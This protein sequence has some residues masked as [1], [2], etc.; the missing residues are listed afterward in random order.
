MDD[1]IDLALDGEQ[2][3]EHTGPYSATDNGR[4]AYGHEVN[5]S[6]RCQYLNSTGCPRE[7]EKLWDPEAEPDGR[8]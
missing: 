3:S 5:G 1:D 2:D 4:D 6:G 7:G 8:N